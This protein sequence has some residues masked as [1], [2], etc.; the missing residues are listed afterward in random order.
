MVTREFVGG[1]DGRFS[2][3]FMRAV[4]FHNYDGDYCSKKNGTFVDGYILNNRFSDNKVIH[5]KLNPNLENYSEEIFFEY[6]V[7]DP[8]R[9]DLR[10]EMAE[11]MKN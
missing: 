3:E 1:L 11:R 6:D 9:I 8:K 2:F 4:K 7:G 5:R 10:I